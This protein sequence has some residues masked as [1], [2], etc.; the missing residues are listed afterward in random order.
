MYHQSFRYSFEIHQS[1]ICSVVIIIII[2]FTI[3]YLYLP[4]TYLYVYPVFI[5]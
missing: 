1:P 2:I 4:A 3:D 5:S